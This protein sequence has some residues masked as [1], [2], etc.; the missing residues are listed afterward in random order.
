MLFAIRRLH[1]ITLHFTAQFIT[2]FERFP[3]S[4]LISPLSNINRI[5]SLLCRL[6]MFNVSSRSV[7]LKQSLPV[8]F[9]NAYIVIVYLNIYN[10]YWG[11]L[12][13]LWLSHLG[14]F[15]YCGCFNLYCGCFNLF[16]MSGCFGNMCTC[17]YS[18][19]YCLYCVLYCLFM[20]IC[21]YLF[22]LY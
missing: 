15:L 5:Y 16:L 10:L 6:P 7:F 13:I 18:V 8:L 12:I 3:K 22:C 1:F 17:I 9:E 2:Y 20:H 21:S 4:M 14:Y 11:Y 19:L